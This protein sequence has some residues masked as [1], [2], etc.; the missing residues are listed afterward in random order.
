V[1]AR[2]TG[3]GVG[4]GDPELITLKG[5]KRLQQA[6]VVAY[7]AGLNGRPGV[8]ERIVADWLQ[9]HQERLPLHFPYVLDAQQLDQAWEAAAET[10]L[11]HLRVGREVAFVSEGDIGFYSTYAY[12]AAKLQAVVPDGTVE[13]IPGVCSPLAAAARLGQP[14]TR[15]NQRLAVLPALYAPEELTAALEWA[16]VVVLMKVASV[17]PRIRPILADHGLLERSWLVE[18]VGW[19]EERLLGT[20]ASAPSE[21]LS[22]FTMLL[23]E[24]RPPESLES[25]AR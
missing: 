22:Y 18:R 25:V 24:V 12:L 15:Q 4:P 1:S 11:S 3:I 6:D 14:L 7:P 19:P 23:V 16:D 17:L 13:A 8:A 20:L 5:L 9:P 21:D 10:V 2:L